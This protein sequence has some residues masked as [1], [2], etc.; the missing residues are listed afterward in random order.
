MTID[1]ACSSSL[2][3]LHQAIAAI[4]NGEIDTAI[5]GGVNMLLDPTS[6]IGFS[7]AH[8]LSPTGL[9]QPFSNNAD[10]YVRAEGAVALV[11]KKC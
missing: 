7:A 4:E 3:A 2:I 9:C 10:G 8:M 1:T 5:V 6:F 11:L